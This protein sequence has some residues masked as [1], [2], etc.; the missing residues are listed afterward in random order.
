MSLSEC[1]NFYTHNAIILIFSVP[2]VNMLRA[3]VLVVVILTVNMK[4]FVSLGVFI[5]IIIILTVVILL[6]YRVPFCS[7]SW[8]QTKSRQSFKVHN[9]FVNYYEKMF[10]RTVT[11]LQH[12]L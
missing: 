10:Y 7:V 3:I 12:S 2:Y 11:S 6:F 1:L 9:F 4:S 8:R 5:L